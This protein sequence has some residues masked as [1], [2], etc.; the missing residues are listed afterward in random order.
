MN[1]RQKR[2]DQDTAKAVAR[3]INILAVRD[4]TLA[5]NYMEYKRV[6][7]SVIARVLDHPD[8]RRA[9]SAEQD[10]SE[11]ITPSAAKP[12]ED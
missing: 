8:S 11:A 9:S 10:I 6:P 4:R 12:T 1:E 7:P 3:G 5:K 2:S